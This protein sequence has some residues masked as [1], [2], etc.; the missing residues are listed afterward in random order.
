MGAAIFVRYSKRSNLFSSVQQTFAVD[1]CAVE[2]TFNKTFAVFA[3]LNGRL[4]YHAIT[5]QKCDLNMSVLKI[6]VP[7]SVLILDQWPL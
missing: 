6:R 4:F 7:Y 5:Y 1:N 2:Q 3:V